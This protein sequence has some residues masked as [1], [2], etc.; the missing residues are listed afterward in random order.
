[1]PR[2]AIQSVQWLMK[3]ETAPGMVAKRE[4]IRQFRRNIDLDARKA[5]LENRQQ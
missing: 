1:M 4:L 3:Y 5:L 2:H